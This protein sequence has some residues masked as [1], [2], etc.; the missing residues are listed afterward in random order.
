[1]FTIAADEY[2]LYLSPMMGFGGQQKRLTPE[3]AAEQLW[4]NF[5]EQAGVTSD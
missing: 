1:M 4:E 2:E 3:A 5:L